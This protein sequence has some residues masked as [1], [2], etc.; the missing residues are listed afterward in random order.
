MENSENLLIA[1]EEYY[2]IEVNKANN[3]LYFTALKNWIGI[4]YFSH[5]EAQWKEG[6]SHLKANFT[7]L[8][9]IRLM[10]IISKALEKLFSEIQ[11]YTI[12][13]GVLHV[14]EVAAM[15]DI[16]NLQLEQISNRSELPFSRFKTFEE[17][18]KYLD[19]LSFQI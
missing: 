18:E 17:A 4:N 3:R 14:A 6:L 8:A 11:A 12:Q 10:P 7:V 2:R 5:L 15:N 16:S 1:Q 9:D 19:K 13:N